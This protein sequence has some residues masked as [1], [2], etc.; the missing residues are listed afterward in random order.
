MEQASQGPG[1]LSIEEVEQPIALSSWSSLT[2]L[3]HSQTLHL[4]LFVIQRLLFGA[5]V[6]GA[7]TILTFLGLDMARG[8]PLQEAVVDAVRQSVDYLLHL[9]QGDLGTSQS[10]TLAARAM[11]VAEV[12]W[13][14]VSKSLGLLTVALIIATVVGTIL[15]IWAARRRRSGWSVATIVASIL[16]GSR[17]LR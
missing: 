14:V 3:R 5:V 11:P 12:L 7:I 17:P 16:I 1:S 9:L 8:M 4:A 15:G 6:L 13:G 10:G 2:H